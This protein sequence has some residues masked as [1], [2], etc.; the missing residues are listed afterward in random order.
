MILN[1]K[2]T[3]IRMKK[4]YLFIFLVLMSFTTKAQQIGMYSHY[5]YKPMIYNPAFTGNGDVTNVFLVSRSQWV[6]FKNSPQLNIVTIDGTLMDKAGLGFGLI[7]DRK[8]LSN[9]IGG[10]IAYSY[11]LKLNENTSLRFGIS[12]GVIDQTM[13]YS[14]AI[15]EDPSDPTLFNEV[16]RK[17]TFDG[18]AGLAFIWKNLEVGAAVPQAIGNKVNY[19]ENTD[20]RS[21]YAQTRH[22]MGSLKYKIVLSKNKGLSLTPLALVRFVS[23]APFQYDGNLNFDWNDK[24]WLGATYKSNYAVSANVGIRIH[25]QLYVGY[26]YDFIIGNIG[27]YSGMAHELMLNFKFGKKEKQAAPAPAPK[28]DKKALENKAYENRMD[29]LENLEKQN[30]QKIKELLE[31]LEQQKNQQ[32]QQQ[33]TQQ[34]QQTEVP[35]HTNDNQNAQVVAD[36][37]NKVQ[38]NGIWIIT[39]QTKD[40]RDAQDHEPQKGFYVIVGTFFYRDL[41]IAETKRFVDKG[42]PADWVFYEPKKYNY[43]YT[44]RVSTKAEALHKAKELNAQGVSEVWIEELIK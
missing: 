41:G 13:D 25:K 37:I 36:N 32:Q 42:F 38:E 40:F 16:Q 43:V 10:N 24:F 27:S 39:N 5:Y 2:T 35:S 29:S 3:F 12:I 30:Q 34:N 1:Q 33:Q 7:T 6:D 21:Y 9:R 8:G 4:T 11:R 31:Q 20:V 44:N 26:S 23:N 14:K 22:Y 15:V 19:V 28:E 17:T 18:N